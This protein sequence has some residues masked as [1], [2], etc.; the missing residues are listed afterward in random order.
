MS[1]V[2]NGNQIKRVS[3]GSSRMVSVWE[4]N[5]LKFPN[6]LIR[7]NGPVNASYERDAL[8]QK[9]FAS[10][11]NAQL[12]SSAYISASVLPANY[13][14]LRGFYCYKSGYY[15][16]RYKTHLE[17]VTGP[18]TSFRLQFSSLVYNVYTGLYDE[19]IEQHE[20]ETYT[21]YYPNSIDIDWDGD[22]IEY[23]LTAGYWYVISLTSNVRTYLT[24]SN[25]SASIVYRG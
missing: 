15:S 11:E 9:C 19:N 20:S 16:I 7:N 8:A 25:A 6:G 3:V 5:N 21:V 13:S 12:G 14:A 2:V 17:C 4:G 10:S 1:I 24:E 23:L 22:G 18:G